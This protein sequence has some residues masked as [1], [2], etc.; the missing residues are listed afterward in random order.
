M[1]DA[2]MSNA[3]ISDANIS[4]DSMGDASMTQAPTDPLAASDEDLDVARR[5]GDAMYASDVAAQ[6]MGIVLEEIGPGF[7]RMRMSV[8]EDMVNGHAICHGGFVFA[9][10]DT[11]FAYACNSYNRTTVAASAAIEFLA[12]AYSDDVL[13]AVAQEEVRG[14]RLGVY[15]IVVTN[16]KNERLALFRGRSYQVRGTVTGEEVPE[17]NVRR[18]S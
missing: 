11:A 5:A 13:T 12:S 16:Q 7:A 4:G 14:A 9:L 1:S 6:K 8:R 18:Q 17:A 2:S 15:D 10:A 3:N